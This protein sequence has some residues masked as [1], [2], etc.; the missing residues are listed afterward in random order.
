MADGAH[1]VKADIEK[2][3]SRKISFG[4]VKMAFGLVTACPKGK[5]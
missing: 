2:K 4:L 1:K 5:L 3:I